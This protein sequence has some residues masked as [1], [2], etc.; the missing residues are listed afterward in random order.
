MEEI[1][2]VVGISDYPEPADRLAF[3]TADARAVGEVLS[4]DE[5]G[6]QVIPLADEEATRQNIEDFLRFAFEEKPRTLVFYFAGHGCETTF[7][8]YLVTYDGEHMREGFPLSELARYADRFA[9]Q[10]TS[11]VILLDCCH[12][13]AAVPSAVDGRPLDNRAI[14]GAFGHDT[15]ARVVIAACR[16][17]EESFELDELEHGIF[18][19]ALIEALEGGAVDHEGRITVPAVYQLV[20]HRLRTMAQQP[21]MRGTIAGDYALGQGFPPRLGSPTPADVVGQ[22]VD[23]AR[24]FVN[25]IDISEGSGGAW[26]TSRFAQAAQQCDGVLE[27]FK[28]QEQR[29]P[30][31]G[32]NREF[33]MARQELEGHRRRFAILSEGLKLPKGREVHELL[34][35]GH[36]GTVYR[37]EEQG[38]G[39]PLAY[40]VL[41]TANLSTDDML[42]RFMNGYEAMDKLDHPRVVKVYELTE[43]PLGFFMEFVGGPNFRQ[44]GPVIQKEPVPLVKFL[45]SVAETVAHAHERS[46][47]H[48][49]IKPENIIAK[50]SESDGVWEAFLTDFDLAWYSTR[51]MSSKEAY[52]ALHYAAPEQ[53]MRPGSN[54]AHLRTVDVF[55]FGKLCYFA[56]VAQDPSPLAGPNEN[57]VRRLDVPLEDW[58]SGKA[59]AEFLELFKRCVVGDHRRRP[60][61]FTYII[62]KLARIL[63]L[64]RDLDTGRLTPTRMLEELAFALSGLNSPP[65]LDGASASFSTLSNRTELRVQCDTIDDSTV[66]VTLVVQPLDRP[67]FE[68]STARQAHDLYR[69]RVDNA[70]SS[71]ALKGERVGKV[72]GDFSF[73]VSLDSVRLNLSGLTTLQQAVSRILEAAEA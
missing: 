53:L 27:W 28:R 48:R 10:G 57:D 44:I 60:Q 64:L 7:E 16:A 9:A 67:V 70:V 33:E 40:K 12:S 46:V 71:V 18:T 32:H 47:I 17:T 8:N 35:S 3:C 68:G 54:E 69:R 4:R 59:A 66:K 49:D 26:K 15:S 52:G 72:Q 41:H 1:A 38:R 19:S 29:H 25:E 61:D 51:S 55:S 36:F 14:E 2:I 42:R 21:V 31:I 30:D 24:R 13:G 58:P 50:Y 65:K 39:T 11:V 6:F 56:A 43:F 62:D 73:K 20:A 45:L 34:G 37:V 23:D 5:Y 63:F 22:L